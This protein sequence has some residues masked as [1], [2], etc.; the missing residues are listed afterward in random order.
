[1]VIKRCETVLDAA[2][3]PQPCTPEMTASLLDYVANMA[4]RGLRT[5]ALAMRRLPEEPSGS[6]APEEGM[7]L[8]GLLGIQVQC[9][10]PTVKPQQLPT[11]HKPLHAGPCASRGTSSSGVLSECGHSSTNGDG[12]QPAHSAADCT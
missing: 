12:R 4:N 7:C 10:N 11:H 9:K 2:G 8:I 6:V 1:M 5:L 3:T